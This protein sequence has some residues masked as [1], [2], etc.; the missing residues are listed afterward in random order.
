AN[1]IICSSGAGDGFYATYWGLS[2]DGIPVC[3]VTDFG[4]LSHHVQATQEL[5]PLA[6]LLGR[7]LWLKLPGGEVQF[8]VQM[9]NNS[10]LIVETSGEGAGTAEFELR[11]GGERIQQS[12]GTTSYGGGRRTVETRFEE[13]VSDQAVLVICH[14]ERIEPL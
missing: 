6:A 2:A 7:Q 13:P 4:L 3:L 11:Q 10:T 5:G 1:L 8:I 9:P 12:G 14:L